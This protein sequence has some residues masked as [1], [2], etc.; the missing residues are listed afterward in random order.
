MLTSRFAAALDR[1]ITREP[2]AEDLCFCAR[3]TDRT[4][5]AEPATAEQAAQSGF[6]QIAA[7]AAMSGAPMADRGDACGTL[8]DECG[9]HMADPRGPTCTGCLASWFTPGVTVARDVSEG[10]RPVIF[11]GF[12]LVSRAA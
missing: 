1:W 7:D 6:P 4:D 2:P 9:R 3:C 8:C 12:V 11:D 5:R 10:P